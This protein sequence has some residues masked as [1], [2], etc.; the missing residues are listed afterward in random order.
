MNRW[1][2]GAGPGGSSPPPPATAG[3]ETC[4]GGGGGRCAHALED[5]GVEQ[6]RVVDDAPQRHAEL[7]VVRLELEARA[8]GDRGVGAERPVTLPRA[9]LRRGGRGARDQRAEDGADGSCLSHGVYEN[10]AA[11]IVAERVGF[12]PTVRFPVHSIS[13]AASSTT[14]APLRDFIAPPS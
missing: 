8:A 3:G 9:P 11:E 13:S 2:G 12:E 14:P 1:S 10:A 5:D 4:W 7:E 6:L